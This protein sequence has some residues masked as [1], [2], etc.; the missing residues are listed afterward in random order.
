[1]IELESHVFTEIEIDATADQVWAVL[2]DFKKLPEW[3]SSFTKRGTP[4]VG[5]GMRCWGVKTTIFFG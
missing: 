4:L 5:L 3:S 1:M 2:T